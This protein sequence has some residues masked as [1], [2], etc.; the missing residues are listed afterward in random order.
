MADEGTEKEKCLHFIS[1]FQTYSEAEL[2]CGSVQ[3]NLINI[4]DAKEMLFVTGKL[5]TFL[6]SKSLVS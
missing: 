1:S 3:G 2:T 6:V 5:L 4:K